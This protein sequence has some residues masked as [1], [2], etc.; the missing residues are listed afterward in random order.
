MLFA[1][2]EP[3]ELIVAAEKENRLGDRLALQEEAKSLPFSAVWDQYCLRNDVPVGT[4][5]LEDVRT[6][7]KDVLLKRG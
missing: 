5:W 3:T 1:L 6:Y 7:E 4:A 2:L